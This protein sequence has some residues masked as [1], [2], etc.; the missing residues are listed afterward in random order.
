[1]ESKKST[2]FAKKHDPSDAPDAAIQEALLTRVKN[3]EIPCAVAFQVAK[4][5]SVALEDVGRTLDLTNIRLTKCQLG[6]FG[7]TP[8]KKIVSARMPEH[9]DLK[10]AI[11]D[12]L[13]DHRLPCTAAWDIADRLG[14]RKMVVS[15]ACEALEI[16]I[17]P[18][19][20]GAL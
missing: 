6:L 2:N 17:K 3:E 8:E 16:K 9:P 12:A 14:V 19:Q 1:M 10:A 18:C 7:Y 5:L 13:V 20:L 11:R 15:A 4:D